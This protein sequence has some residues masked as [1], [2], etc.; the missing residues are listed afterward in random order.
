LNGDNKFNFAFTLTKDNEIIYFI[1][2]ENNN[3][4]CNSDLDKVYYFSEKNKDVKKSFNMDYINVEQNA[5][6]PV[7]YNEKEKNALDKVLG[8]TKDDYFG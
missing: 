7:S 8:K 3:I 5:E 1:V 2:D 4:L 6:I